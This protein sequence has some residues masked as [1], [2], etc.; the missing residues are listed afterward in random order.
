MKLGEWWQGIEAEVFWVPS[1]EFRTG[2]A[3]YRSNLR[4]LGGETGAIASRSPTNSK[5]RLSI[6][7]SIT[8]PA[9][10]QTAKRPGR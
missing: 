5:G 7:R 6:P 1:S 3:L 8:T 10:I 2:F 4:F 9:I